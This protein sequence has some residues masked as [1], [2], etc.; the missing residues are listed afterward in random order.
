MRLPAAAP[1]FTPGPD[2]PIVLVEGH[3]LM[4]CACGHRHIAHQD[5]GDGVAWCRH[6]KCGC[7]TFEG[8]VG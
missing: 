7:S 1:G 2:E 6:P 8:L 5:W 4:R 3:R